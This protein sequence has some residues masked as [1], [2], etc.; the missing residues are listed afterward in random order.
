M[1]IYINNK[2]RTLLLMD[3]AAGVFSPKQSRPA[4]D[5]CCRK[6]VCPP[7]NRPLDISRQNISTYVNIYQNISTYINIYQ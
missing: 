4:P 3:A 5:R 1:Y 2:I 7:K 6:R